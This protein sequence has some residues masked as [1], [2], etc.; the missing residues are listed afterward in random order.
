V[1]AR[2]SD[3][4][5][6]LLLVVGM[7]VLLVL[8]VTVVVDVTALFLAR[9]DLLAAA[10]GAALAGA[11]AVDAERLYTDGVGAG[12]LPLDPAE[13]ERA[14]R[15]YVA[16]TGVGHGLARL[17]V[18]VVATGTTVTVR[19]EGIARLPFV[20]DVT[21]GAAAGVRVSASA[22]ASTAVVSG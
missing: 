12:P 10:D 7:V 15:A 3:D 11:Q 4:G 9:K 21:P 6:V 18:E 20:S 22:T 5:S 19:L 1:R 16:D 2:P 17:D 8:L 13:A 14:A